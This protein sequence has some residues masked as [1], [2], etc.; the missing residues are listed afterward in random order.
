MLSLL[1]SGVLV[2]VTTLIHKFSLAL[3]LYEFAVRAKTLLEVAV[4]AI[5]ALALYVGGLIGHTACSALL[6]LIVIILG[7]SHLVGLDHLRL[8]YRFINYSH[9]LVLT[10]PLQRVFLRA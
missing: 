10:D 1:R 7:C 3:S 9:L 6:I 4:R 8:V 2:F 5:V